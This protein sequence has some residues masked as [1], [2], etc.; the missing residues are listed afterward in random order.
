MD[1]TR[2][3]NFTGSKDLS[4]SYHDSTLPPILFYL[5]LQGKPEHWLFGD[6][7]LSVFRRVLL[8]SLL[9]LGGTKTSSLYTDRRT[10]GL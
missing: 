7:I 1:S 6:F 4:C 8:N 5:S 2:T 3:L 9:H 10:N